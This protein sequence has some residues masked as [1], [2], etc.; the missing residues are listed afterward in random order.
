MDKSPII[1]S[2]GGSILVPQQIDVDS[3]KKFKELI[4][5][6][7]KNG[8]R[9]AIVAGGGKTARNYQEAARAIS[10]EVSATDA[11]WVGI[12]ATK[13]NAELLRAIFAPLS[14]PHVVDNPSTPVDFKEAILIGAGY[15]PGCSTDEDAVLMAKNIGAKKLI[16]LSNINYVYDKDPRK[17]PNA[18]IIEDISWAEFRKII[19]EKWEPG[20]SSPFDPIAAKEAESFGLEVVVMNGNNLINLDAYLKGEPFKG[21]RIH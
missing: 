14:H 10:P 15:E 8:I 19:P 7:T 4:I 5:R 3:I 21:T 11:D 1:I 6:H 13:L 20:M 12:G 17:F 2:V 16:N 18:K 9:F